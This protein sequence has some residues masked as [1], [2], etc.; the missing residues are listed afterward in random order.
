M[1]W[2]GR[3]GMKD[4][5]RNG[6]NEGS[7]LTDGHWYGLWI[8][9]TLAGIKGRAGVQSDWEKWAGDMSDYRWRGRLREHKQFAL[10]C[11]HTKEGR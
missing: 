10:F 4:D 7:S 5:H 9:R 6:S 1:G 11:R 8:M 2:D 3:M